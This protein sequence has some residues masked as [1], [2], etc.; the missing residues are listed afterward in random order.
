[1]LYAL[2]SYLHEKSDFQRF[3]DAGCGCGIETCCLSMLF[4]EKQFIGYDLS[5]NMI[6]LAE[7][8]KEKL[9]LKN[10][11]LMPGDHDTIHLED[12]DILYNN[13]S[14]IEEQHF[15]SR[16]NK[17]TI[18]KLNE[19]KSK[20]FWN[21]RQMLDYNGIYAFQVFLPSL[22][23]SP[24]YGTSKLLEKAINNRY[25]EWYL[26]HGFLLSSCVEISTDESMTHL[27]V[28]MKKWLIEGVD[29]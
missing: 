25:G 4:P 7:K 12:I 16:E 20:R 8:R 22:K 1:M 29:F 11:T 21:L 23:N 27:L 15:M 5:P 3:V 9:G 14:L 2:A 19:L 10:L 13:S 17:N 26:N 24:A 28:L 6:H 18:K